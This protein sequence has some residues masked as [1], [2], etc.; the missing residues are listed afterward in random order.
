MKLLTNREYLALQQ[1][2]TDAMRQANDERIKRLK[3][4]AQ[5]LKEQL[6]FD[7]LLSVNNNL[8]HIS[9][10]LALDCRAIP[11]LKQTASDLAW[12]LWGYELRYG[13]Q[14]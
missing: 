9:R 6:D 11:Y 7:Q 10:A 4:E 14:G 5:L 1:D 8:I 13:K 3:A 12:Q 2:I